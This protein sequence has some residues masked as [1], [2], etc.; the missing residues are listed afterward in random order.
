M[1][2]LILILFA[3]SIFQITAQKV[4]AVIVG[5]ADYRD[6]AI[7]DLNYSD[8][9][10]NEYYQFLIKK[11]PESSSSI[12]LLT[13]Q[14]ATKQNI[15]IKLKEVFKNSKKDDLLIFFFSGH[16]ANGYFVPYDCTRN[17]NLLYHKEIR[18]AFSLTPA[19]RK[20]V[21]ADACRSGS[22]KIQ[23][24]HANTL[25]KLESYYKH[26]KRMKGGIALMLSSRWNQNS[27]ESS[28]FQNGYFAYY[29]LKGLKGAADENHDNQIVID[30]LYRYVRAQVKSVSNDQQIPIIFGQFSGQML[31]SNL[32]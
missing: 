30:E 20:L 1:R 17:N 6:N 10:A 3:C 28:Y 13:E 25:F 9:D 4:R 32:N 23:T 2:T 31:V 11:H 19:T 15:L 12:V 8:D 24:Q 14:R 29:L 26:L 7:R 16:G 21:F 18:E 5:V 22:I 27:S